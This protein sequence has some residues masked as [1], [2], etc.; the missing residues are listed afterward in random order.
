MTFRSRLFAVA[1]V[2]L[3]SRSHLAENR[4]IDGTFTSS[5]RSWARQ[6]SR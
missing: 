1:L 2:F 3:L 4:T 6:I 5:A